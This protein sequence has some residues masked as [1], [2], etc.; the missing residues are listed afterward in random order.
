M[1]NNKR[2][3]KVRPKAEM[4]T[5]WASNIWL[6]FCGHQTQRIISQLSASEPSPSSTQY[7]TFTYSCVVIDMSW[8]SRVELNG[9][10][11]G[12]NKAIGCYFGLRPAP[13]HESPGKTVQSLQS[14]RVLLWILTRSQCMNSSHTWWY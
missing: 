10:L 9:A 3:L 13:L 2:R 11:H 14:A 6:C 8:Q 4:I 7:C 1:S 12:R 5:R